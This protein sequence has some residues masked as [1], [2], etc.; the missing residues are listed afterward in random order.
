MIDDR[1]FLSQIDALTKQGF[2]FV[3]DDYGTGYSNLTR[4][5][6]CPFINIKLDMEVVWDYCNKPDEI[7][8]MMTQAFK[9]M[10]FSITAEGIENKHMADAMK[11]LGCDYF[12][13]F[14]Y[15]KPLPMEDFIR[16]LRMQA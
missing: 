8:P 7:L 14:Y 6:K 4:L 16:R 11:A 9:H 13:G 3:L 12:Q 10:D 1:F 2:K 5:K 15:S